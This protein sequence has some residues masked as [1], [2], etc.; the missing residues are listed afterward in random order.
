MINPAFVAMFA[1]ILSIIA[2]VMAFRFGK[3]FFKILVVLLLLFLIL[4]GVVGAVVYNDFVNFKKG[5]ENSKNLILLKSDEKIIAGVEV[6]I[7]P[8]ERGGAKIYDDIISESGDVRNYLEKV[9]SGSSNNTAGTN[10]VFLRKD[11]IAELQANYQSDSIEE[12][13]LSNF[14]MIIFELGLLDDLN[15]QYFDLSNVQ[16]SKEK[17]KEILLSEN[18]L[19]VFS[20]LVA[21]KQGVSAASVKS[22][23]ESQGYTNQ[24][25]KDFIFAGVIQQ[26]FLNNPSQM[27]SVFGHMKNGNVIVYPKTIMFKVFTMSPEALTVILTENF[28]GK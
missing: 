26:V 23:L 28:G 4:L 21:E 20:E 7:V 8:E 9:S 14:K 6:R 17:V 18:T 27:I 10:I 2:I 15:F 3:I 13:L 25:L 24:L 5:I 22:S 11:K 12:M 1:V 16:I 19:T